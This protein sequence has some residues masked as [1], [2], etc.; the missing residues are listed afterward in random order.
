MLADVLVLDRRVRVPKAHGHVA[1][2]NRTVQLFKAAKPTCTCR[3]KHAH[4]G[5]LLEAAWEDAK[6]RAEDELAGPEDCA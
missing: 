3:G 6:A 1:I 4:P 5:C 2:R